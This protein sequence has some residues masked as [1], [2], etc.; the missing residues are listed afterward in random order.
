[1]RGSNFYYIIKVK[2]G[3]KMKKTIKGFVLGVIITTM[4][5]STVFGAQVKKTIDVIF[6]SVNITLNGE[7][8]DTDNF[9]YEG[10]TYVPLRA[11]SEI[12]GKEV[13]WDGDTNTASIYDKETDDEKLIKEIGDSIKFTKEE[14]GEAIKAVETDFDFLASTLTKIWYNEK[15]S[16][17]FT[18]LYLKYGNGSVNEAKSENV[19]VLLS[20]FYVDDS[21]DNPV[22]NS[23]FTY[24]NY[25]WILIRDDKASDWKIDDRG[26]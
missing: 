3:I 23:D 2:G 25:Q 19:I 14:I 26:Y 7:K 11:I 21:V 22:L 1:M 15:E 5:M 18:K 12:F 24:E 6:N 9:L 20:N 10:T 4:L 8:S 13:G 17:K 16:D